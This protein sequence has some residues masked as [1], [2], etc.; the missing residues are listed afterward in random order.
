[1]QSVHRIT[2]TSRGQDQ[3]HMSINLDQAIV[4]AEKYKAKSNSTTFDDE[5]VEKESYWFFP[6]GFMGSSGVI[7][8]KSDGRLHVMGSSLSRAEMFWGHENGFSPEKLDIE[9]YE[10]ND[11]KVTSNLV[12]G[13]L[14][15]LS[16]MPNQPRRASR[17]A[18]KKLTEKLPLSL[19]G[20]SLWLKIP[21]FKEAKEENWFNYT[22][23]E[24]Q[25][26]DT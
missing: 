1:M 10:I 18:A 26:N 7:I 23:S 3:C 12:A 16:K 8:D 6:I 13:L 2:S 20:V 15:Q 24:H 22:I 5:I 14:V 25:S 19:K 21:L 11:S 4:I 9:I 17:E